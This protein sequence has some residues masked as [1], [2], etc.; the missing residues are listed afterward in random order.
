M[1]FSALHGLV[2]QHSVDLYLAR[3]FCLAIIIRACLLLANRRVC[4]LVH[5]ERPS[6]LRRRGEPRLGTNVRFP[7]L[8]VRGARSMFTRVAICTAR[9]PERRLALSRRISHY[10]LKGRHHSITVADLN[11]SFPAWASELW[12]PNVGTHQGT[13][14]LRFACVIDKPYS[15][16]YWPGVARFWTMGHACAARQQS[17]TDEP[18]T[19]SLQRIGT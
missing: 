1:F 18:T 12:R 2:I 9:T 4:T 13:D 5:A 3:A 6:K 11:S 15:A 19:C 10:S 14:T 7:I 17:P 16:V 8:G